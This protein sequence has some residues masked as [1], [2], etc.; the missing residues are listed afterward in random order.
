MIVGL[1]PT[2]YKFVC[3][4]FLLF[5]FYVCQLAICDLI[6]TY[7]VQAITYM[8]GHVKYQHAGLEYS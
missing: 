1:G 6:M 2:L 4:Q 8:I 3:N 7:R 5:L